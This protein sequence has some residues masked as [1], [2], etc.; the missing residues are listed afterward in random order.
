MR[1][2]TSQLK[3]FRLHQSCF[4]V[5]PSWWKQHDKE[6]IAKRIIERLYWVEVN[7]EHFFLQ[8]TH[9]LQNFVCILAILEMRTFL[10]KVF[11]V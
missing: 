2:I 11:P 10:Q 3:Y 1:K 5:N 4:C 6:K 7:S 8:E 9:H